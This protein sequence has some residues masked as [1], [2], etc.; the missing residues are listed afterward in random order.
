[1][2]YLKQFK[3][4]WKLGIAFLMITPTVML[5]EYLQNN[6]LISHIFLL[7]IIYFPITLWLIV[8]NE[9]TNNGDID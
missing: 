4:N 1:M 8:S 2:S 9:D 7:Y 6:N 3:R 5:I